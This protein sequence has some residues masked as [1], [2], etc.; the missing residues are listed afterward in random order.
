MFGGPGRVYPGFV[1][2]EKGGQGGGGTSPAS[3]HKLQR[4]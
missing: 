1:V 4:L 3:G 2:Y